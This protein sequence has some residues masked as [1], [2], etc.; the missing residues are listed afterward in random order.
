MDNNKLKVLK[1]IGYTIL[2]CCGNCKSSS[3]P[4]PSSNFGT[5]EKFKYFHI[6]HNETRDISIN[7]FG[8]CRS[9]QVDDDSDTELKVFK[10]YL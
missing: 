8:R 7:R 5:C 6:K 9:S 4:S 10:D 1:D 3:F 2:S